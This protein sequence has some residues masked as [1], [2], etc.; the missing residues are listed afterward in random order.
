MNALSKKIKTEQR[1]GWEY[2]KTEKGQTEKGG[3]D[4]NPAFSQA[5]KQTVHRHCLEK[6]VKIITAQMIHAL[7][8]GN[9]L[10]LAFQ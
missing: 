4:T 8:V 2:R 6:S 3:R 7:I 9:L 1:N 10:P 5:Q